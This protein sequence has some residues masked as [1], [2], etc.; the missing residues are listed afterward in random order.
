LQNISREVKLP[1]IIAGKNP[2]S[3][4][5]EL[6]S[7]TPNTTLVESP[8]HDEMQRLIQQAHV[9][10]LITFQPTGLKLKLLNALYN[11]R[12]CVANKEML[13]GSGLESLVEMANNDTEIITKIKELEK[14]KFS[15]ED[16]EN[17]KQFL[18]NLYSTK[19]RINLMISNLF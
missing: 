19:E 14:R 1:L 9:N 3:D 10:L 17:R 4:L 18:N 11:G 5:V 13:F 16:I 2:P 15:I 7:K 6:I 12:F 8:T